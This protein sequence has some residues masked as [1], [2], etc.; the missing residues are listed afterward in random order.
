MSLAL[1]LLG[2]RVWVFLEFRGFRLALVWAEIFREF[3]GLRLWGYRVYRVYGL[4]TPKILERRGS[5]SSRV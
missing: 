2:F 1:G 3:K 4:G 5:K